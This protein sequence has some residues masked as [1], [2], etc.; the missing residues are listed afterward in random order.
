MP[1]KKPTEP[2]RSADST[3]PKKNT[4]AS[5]PLEWKSSGKGGSTEVAVD[6]K[7]KMIYIRTKMEFSGPDASEKYAAAAKKQIEKTWRGQTTQSGKTYRVK[8]TIETKVNT[9]G[10]ATPGY[11]QIVVDAKTK[12]MNQT[13][14]GAGPG[15]QTPDAATDKSRP[16][17][18]A[19]EYGH[20]LG[21]GDDYK[22]EKGKSVPIDP[23]KKNNIMAETWPDKDGNLPHPHDDHYQQVLKNHGH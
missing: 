16:R 15:N 1:K 9:S 19:H 21:L 20:T 10:K 11:D 7:K 18:I 2:S 13:L 8:T 17:R 4:T 14:N 23:T 22:D 5:C 6:E 12:R 3:V